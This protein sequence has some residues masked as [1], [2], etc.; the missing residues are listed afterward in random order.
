[1][2]GCLVPIIL[3]IVLLGLIVGGGIYLDKLGVINLKPVLSKIPVVKNKYLSVKGSPEVSFELLKGE[4]LRKF[5]ESIEMKM[6]ELEKKEEGLVGKEKELSNLEKELKGKDEELRQKDIA[7]QERI[8]A[9]NDQEANLGKMATL[10]QS[11]SPAKSA[12]ILQNLD[13][14]IVIDIFRRME[15]GIVSAVLMQM[16]PQKAAAVSRK[17]SR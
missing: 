9:F 13:D 2:K 10:Y 6:E 11:M 8:D 14:Q 1:M 7:L 12:A 15:E 17:M 4:E 5:Q 16:D 3:L